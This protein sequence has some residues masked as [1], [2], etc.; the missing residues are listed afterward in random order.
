MDSKMSVEELHQQMM[1]MTLGDLCLLCGQA[2]NL[3]FDKE[4]VDLMLKYLEL[5]MRVR[6]LTTKEEVK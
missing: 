1:S 6:K 2:I 4:R 3:G 5:K